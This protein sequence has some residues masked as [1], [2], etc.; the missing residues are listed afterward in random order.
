A[1]IF[2]GDR[3]TSGY[4]LSVLE[5]KRTSKGWILRTSETTPKVDAPQLQVETRPFVFVIV[6]NHVDDITWDH[7]S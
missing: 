7:E 3:P 5:L 1:A 2:L 4:S 6:P